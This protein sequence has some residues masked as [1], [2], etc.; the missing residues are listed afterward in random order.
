MVLVDGR[1]IV[2]DGKIIAFDAEAVLDEIDS[3]MHSVRKRNSNIFGIA[4]RIAQL[5]P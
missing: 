2:E 5:L 1:V 3:M 4:R